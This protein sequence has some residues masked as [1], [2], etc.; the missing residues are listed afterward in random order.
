LRLRHP[1]SDGTTHL[2]FDPVELLERLAVLPFDSAQ[3]TTSAVEGWG[4]EPRGPSTLLRTIPSFA[5]KWRPLDVH[6]VSNAAFLEF[7]EPAGYDNLQW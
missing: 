6:D 2:V 7:V 4:R 1:W 3:G 5:E